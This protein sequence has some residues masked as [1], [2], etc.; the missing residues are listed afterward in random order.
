M[1]LPSPPRSHPVVFTRGA[2][3]DRYQ[4]SGG[5]EGSRGGWRSEFDS[6]QAEV[7]HALHDLHDDSEGE[8][9]SVVWP[10]DQGSEEDGAQ[11]SEQE[12]AAG[13]SSGAR[14][15]S[16]GLTGERRPPQQQQQQQPPSKQPDVGGTPGTGG[17]TARQQRSRLGLHQIDIRSFFSRGA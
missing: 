5:E 12:Q 16:Y 14:R 9:A 15:S 7:T 8:E 13:P 3:A 10:E 6:M 2:C 4:L 11:E 1:W 17:S